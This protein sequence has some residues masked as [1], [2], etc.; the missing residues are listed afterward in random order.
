MLVLL[1]AVITLAAL[2]LSKSHRVVRGRATMAVAVFAI[3]G[4]LIFGPLVRQRFADINLN[5]GLLRTPEAIQPSEDS[6]QWRLLNW[7]I[8]VS[9]GTERPLLGHGA[10]M[11]RELN[12]LVSPDKFVPFDAH[13]DF[14]R[15]F[16][17]AGLLGLIAYAAYAILLCLWT[18]RRAWD[19]V[20]KQAPAALAISSSVLAIYLFTFGTPEVSLNT[21]VQ[22]ELYAWLALVAYFPTITST[23]LSTSFSGDTQA[24]RT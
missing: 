12:P 21:P 22:L 8:L 20:P 23:S 6:F 18:L 19:V 17:E 5:A 15:F 9:M 4:W 24:Q 3:T 1:A 2:Q 16:F 14:V 13:D 10:G 11:T 7:G